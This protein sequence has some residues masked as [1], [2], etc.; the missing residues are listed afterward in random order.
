MRYACDSAT[1]PKDEPLALAWLEDEF[2]GPVPRGRSTIIDRLCDLGYDMRQVRVSFFYRRPLLSSALLPSFR[3][4]EEDYELTFKEGY[5][6][7]QL[8]EPAVAF[9]KI[10]HVAPE[11]QGGII[12]ARRFRE[13]SNALEQSG[14]E[15]QYGRPCPV[16]HLPSLKRLTPQRLTAFYTRAAPF[17][18]TANG[19]IVRESH[20]A[21]GTR[22]SD[23]IKASS[24]RR[25]AVQPR[26]RAAGGLPPEPLTR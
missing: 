5:L 9:I 2:L 7:F 4:V 26:P 11:H 6:R 14:V 24:F 20:L 23:E 21:P 19:F 18:K 16:C 3:H 8:P 17:R 10:F 12:A 22:P 15:R 25:S 1:T 13:I